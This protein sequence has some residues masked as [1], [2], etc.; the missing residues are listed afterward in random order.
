[1]WRNR[2]LKYGV[3]VSEEAC[4]LRE[5]CGLTVEWRSDDRYEKG[6]AQKMGYITVHM[7]RLKEEERVKL[8]EWIDH[9]ACDFHSGYH[10][11]RPAIRQNNAFIYPFEN[12]ADMV[13]FAIAMVPVTIGKNTTHVVFP[14]EAEIAKIW[15]GPEGQV[16]QYNMEVLKSHV[17][18]LSQVEGKAR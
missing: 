15:N 11:N 6:N 7:N 13:F 2:T 17:P 1:M 16:Q 9:S 12:Y 8:K 10:Q 18:A 3:S 14:Q 5:L 4:R